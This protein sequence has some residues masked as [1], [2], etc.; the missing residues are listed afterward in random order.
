MLIERVSALHLGAAIS[1]ARGWGLAVSGAVIIDWLAD[2][3]ASLAPPGRALDLCGN[4]ELL[5]H[6]HRWLG[7]E[8]LN[9]DT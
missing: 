1:T 9:P 6:V 4:L 5:E 3:A 7:C 8:A 2:R